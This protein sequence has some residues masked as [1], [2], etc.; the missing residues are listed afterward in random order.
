MGLESLFSAFCEPFGVSTSLEKALVTEFGEMS[1][2]KVRQGTDGLLQV[3][4]SG[5]LILLI[6]RCLGSSGAKRLELVS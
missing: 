2:G 3:A 1:V 4:L 6:G 5:S